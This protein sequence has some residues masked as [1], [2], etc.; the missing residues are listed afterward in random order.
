MP[1]KRK[2]KTGSAPGSRRDQSAP[3]AP[4][5]H[6]GK[7]VWKSPW[8]R[9]ALA[10]A[11]VGTVAASI[12][13]IADRTTPDETA[14][15]VPLPAPRQVDAP[16]SVVLSDFAGSRACAGC[17][18]AQ[19]AVWSQSTHGQAGGE[20][21]RGSVIVP[22]NGRPI[23]FRDA[24]VTPSV[25]PSGEFSFTIAQDAHEAIVLRVDGVVGGG[26]LAGGGTQGFLTR[27]ADGTLR[28]LPFD[29]SRHERVW[30]CNTSSRTNKGWQPITS[31]LALADCGDWPP[32]R[33]FGDV[34]RFANCQGCHG[35]QVIAQF[36]TASGRYVSS[37]TTLAIN[38]E[39]CHGPGKR[40][41]EL[42]QSGRITG[43]SDI[44]MAA[45]ATL[46]KDQSLQV[47][48]A[49]HAVKDQLRAG[50]LSG[51]PLTDYY[52]LDFP[53][54]GDRPLLP[55]GR[56]RTFAY[57]ENHRYSDCYLSG[58]MTCT[59]CHDPHS[60]KY[61]DVNGAPLIGRFS[62]GQC[63]SCHV[64][65]AE[66]LE[67]HTRHPVQSPGSQC[68]SCHMPYLQHPELGNAI[69]YARADHSI[70]IPR[71][72]FDSSLGITSACQLC[73]TE[74]P[75]SQLEA[76]VTAW[77]GEIKPH[78]PVIASQL[79]AA[80]DTR[81]AAQMLLGAGESKGEQTHRAAQFA[82]M[83]RFFEEY[84][85]PGMQLDKEAESRLLELAES[86][87]IEIRSLAL[88]SLHLASGDAPA[89]RKLLARK[90]ATAAP[91]DRALRDRWALALGFAGDSY[92]SRGRFAEAITAYG[93]AL[94]IRP[95]MAAILLALAN[96]ERDAGDLGASVV[97]YRQSIAA[98]PTQPLAQVNLGIAL[99]AAGDTA[100]AIEAFDRAIS[101]NSREPLA[102]YN[103]ANI[104]YG[105]G[106]LPR[107]I[108]VYRQVIRI[109]PS[110][111]QAHF[112]L[113][114]ALILRREYR[115]ALQSARYG[116]EFAPN[117]P[118]GRAMVRDLTG[119]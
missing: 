64:S 84:L 76:Q 68:V 43:A 14:S 40:H 118:T 100:S 63:T 117:D 26:H 90:L 32:S 34:P 39:S 77:Y 86:N 82:G 48:F 58:S 74:R 75:A 5:P 12:F 53:S 57:Q 41:V 106:D 102:Y 112:N 111:A 8:V 80:S 18:A 35:S 24:V 11:V 107:A 13:F 87:N 110:I 2:A 27:A 10:V 29:Y 21:K 69:R 46:D 30:F 104:H 71:P 70:P 49:C 25:S 96:A 19:Y 22:F 17:H 20:P 89:I 15:R 54:L 73:H 6:D 65:K 88:A 119:R 97:H 98:D 4:G 59:D 79:R 7:L 105:R 95:G 33:I 101:L 116:L 44:G 99:G 47:C 114:R 38:C 23:R 9:L 108:S 56:V 3:A 60:Q 109:D 67:A 92:A 81:S 61:R 66:R 16:P 85:T 45:L 52:T 91:G 36:D 93:K 103:L 37:H 113:A 72:A 78:N 83:S 115:D 42:A 50:Y 51:A 94:E 28:F 31:S 55:D 62:N 1:K